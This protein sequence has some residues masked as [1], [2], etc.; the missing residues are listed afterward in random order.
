M[1]LSSKTGASKI[2]PD[3]ST[4]FLGC[5]LYSK[6]PWAVTARRF[7]PG[8]TMWPGNCDHRLTQEQSATVVAMSPQEG[9]VLRLTIAV[10]NAVTVW[11]AGQR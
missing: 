9:G 10:E 1:G 11:T 6:V 2:D 5:R 7:L 4:D 8:S 3:V